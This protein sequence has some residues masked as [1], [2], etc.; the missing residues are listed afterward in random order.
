MKKIFLGVFCSLI[1]LAD[2]LNSSIELGTSVSHYYDSRSIF[3]NPS[4]LSYQ[5]ALN[6]AR[7]TS[8][9]EYAV[10]EN[11]P[12]DM[13]FSLAYGSLGFGVEKL[14]VLVDP[15]LRF[16]FAGGIAFGKSVFFGGR[17]SFTSS[18]N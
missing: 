13:A 7:L 1:C 4:A 2:P 6:K 8:S 9:F 5:T 11:V 14:S 3:T 17:Y 16:S 12:N 10:S 18:E 15:Y